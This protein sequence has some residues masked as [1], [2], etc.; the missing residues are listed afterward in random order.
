VIVVADTSVLLNLCC[1]GK[2]D[3]LRALFNDV[4]IPPEVADEFGRLASRV[5]RFAGLILPAWVRQQPASVIPPLVQA[6]V[7][8]DLGETAALALAVEINADAILLDERRGHEVALRLGLRTVGVLGILLQA[9]NR[10]L[11]TEVRTLLDRLERE[12]SFWIDPRLRQ[13]VLRLAGEGS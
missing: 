6:A 9:K 10:G 1:V 4:V 13:R 8:L 2:A 11:L 7:G 12:A 5:P 3:L